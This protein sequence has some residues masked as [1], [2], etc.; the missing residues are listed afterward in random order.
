MKITFYAE[1][2]GNLRYEANKKGCHIPAL[3]N[4]ICSD[5]LGTKK[6]HINREISN[7]KK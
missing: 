7:A 5:Y 4:A 2:F 1:L 3:V 6:K